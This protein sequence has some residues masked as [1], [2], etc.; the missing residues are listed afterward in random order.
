[1]F[2]S[3]KSTWMCSDVTYPEEISPL[4][5]RLF[6]YVTRHSAFEWFH[7]TSSIAAINVIPVGHECGC[8]SRS[9]VAVYADDTDTPF[10]GL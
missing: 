8:K 2:L 1:M 9:F 7:V 6:F 3:R 5:Q 10:C 4:L